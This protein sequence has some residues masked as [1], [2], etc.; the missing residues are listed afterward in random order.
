MCYGCASPIRTD[1]STVPAPP[2][3]LIICYKERR[4][5][6]D[7]VTKNLKL[8]PKEENT[9]YHLMKT[10]VLSKHPGFSPHLLY[11]PA[12]LIPSLSGTHKLHVYNNYGIHV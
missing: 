10:C 12:D 2:H 3:D 5:C 6:R 11:I 8:T 1:T 4:Y 9:Y 7:L